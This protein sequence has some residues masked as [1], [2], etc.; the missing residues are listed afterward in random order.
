M[1]KKWV[2]PT[3]LVGALYAAASE[4]ALQVLHYA[5]ETAV[6]W[7]ASGVGLAAMLLLSTGA[8][9]RLNSEAITMRFMV[10]LL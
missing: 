7:F 8:A 1:L 2:L 4:L 3:L 6:V 5:A 10:I 9:A